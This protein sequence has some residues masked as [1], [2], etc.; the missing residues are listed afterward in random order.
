MIARTRRVCAAAGAG[1]TTLAKNNK[2]HR[3]ELAKIDLFANLS[4]QQLSQLEA[5][6]ELL[7]VKGGKA[8][9]REGAP[10]K[11]L[12]LVVSG[13]FH[14]YEQG[15]SKPVAEI[16]TGASI[17]EIG[18]F[19]GSP[20]TATVSAA[21][22][23]L[24]LRLKR[25]DFDAL[26]KRLPELWPDVAAMLARRLLRIKTVDPVFEKSG[27]HTIAVCHAG[28]ETVPDAMLNDVHQPFRETSSSRV[29]T[30]QTLRDEV[31]RADRKRDH[32]VTRWLND[33]E[34]NH[35]YLFFIADAQLSDWSRLAI[36]HADMILFIG[37]AP[38]E[39]PA[40][41]VPLNALERYAQEV[42]HAEA[43]RLVL[44]HGHNGEV[45]GTRYWLEGR[46]VHMHHHVTGGSDADYRRVARF[47]QGKA[48][49]LV[50]CGGGAFC[51]AHIG[52]FQ[53]FN[54]AGLK[55]D[56]M[57]GTS[58]G[59]A[60]V[61]AY[62]KEADPDEL[63]RRTH[64]IFVTR[65]A[66]RRATFP[67]YSLLDHKVFDECLIENYG[68]TRIEDLRIP[69]FAVATNLS[70]NRLTCVREGPLWRSI[71][72]S[73]A[74]PGLLPPL[75]TQEGDMLVDGSLLDNVPLRQ[76]R[77]LKSGPNVIVN[78]EP[79]ELVIKDVVYETLPSRSRLIKAM[80]LPFLSRR[81]P[82]APGPGSILTRSLAVNRRDFSELV[83]EEDL[84]FVPPLPTDMSI[85]DWKR[86]TELKQLAYEYGRDELACKRKSGHP[87]LAGLA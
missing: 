65:G 18:F 45:S 82:K 30:A 79:P 66:L 25:E 33:Q 60:M 78:F 38:A 67:R 15:F 63:D 55:F 27:T 39:R 68:T 28:P 9:L 50:A 35:D 43:Q 36:R 74:I 49:G 44:V 1:S 80:L 64:D 84:V 70:H 42:R 21:R 51:A 61:G 13:R 7:T 2:D 3:H 23:S 73:S 77:Q 48:L 14:V 6:F 87:L 12:Y 20:R 72:A 22:D 32:A 34:A 24:V 62:A 11:A 47:I 53:A 19:S 54:E 31:S 17:G 40:S 29:L 85:L 75:Y 46:K 76:M 59:A 8:L 26:C 58:G 16:G 56:I 57:G 41:P 81:L 83:T 10:S 69:Y 5:K 86:H 52:L 4:E 71:R 37:T